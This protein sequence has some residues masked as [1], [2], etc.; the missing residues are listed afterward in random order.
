MSLDSTLDAHFSQHPEVSAAYL[1]GSQAQGTAR[2]GSDV[3]VAI[4]LDP[5]FDLKAHFAYRL[6]QM[7]ALE[8][9]CQRPVDVVILNQA[10]SVLRHQVLKYG[11][12][13]Y[14]RAHRQRVTFEVQSRLAYFDFKPTLDFLY[15]RL[16]RDI[17]E[18]NL[19]T[20]Y[21]GRRDPIDDARRARE[22][23]ESLAK[24]NL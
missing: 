16:L 13:V 9:L 15:D 5:A 23:F 24:D 7:A 2:P 21:R 11:R 14:E 10:P 6:E 17:K 8:T 19:G 3:D 1:F 22:R 18:G 20:R 4:L 12:L